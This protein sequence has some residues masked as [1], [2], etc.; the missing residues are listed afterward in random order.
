V[1]GAMLAKGGAACKGIPCAEPPVGDLRWREPMPTKRWR[2]VR[3]A[4]R[5]GA[6][7]PQVRLRG[8]VADAAEISEDCLSLNVARSRFR[9]EHVFR[10]PPPD[11]QRFRTLS[12]TASMQP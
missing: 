12:L 8:L 3:E 1:R 2:G 10:V 11:L 6:I 5:Y 4:T 9:I 7:C